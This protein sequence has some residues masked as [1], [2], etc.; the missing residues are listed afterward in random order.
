L[1]AKGK[2]RSKSPKKKETLSRKKPREGGGLGNLVTGTG[3]ALYFPQGNQ[4][5]VTVVKTIGN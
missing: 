3:A 2:K 1:V 4:K 5:R